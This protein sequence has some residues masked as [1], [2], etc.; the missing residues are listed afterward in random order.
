MVILCHCAIQ[1]VIR[2]IY[3]V[4]NLQHW[5]GVGLHNTKLKYYTALVYL[6]PS[7]L[8]IQVHLVRT[9]ELWAYKGLFLK[10]KVFLK[11]LYGLRNT[12]THGC[13]KAHFGYTSIVLERKKCETFISFFR[14]HLS[15]LISVSP[16]Y[17]QRK[18]FIVNRAYTLSRLL[19]K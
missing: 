15:Y 11:L 4:K 7:N 18:P 14:F 12:I 9:E 17:V 10:T 16:T 19:L 6:Y 13:F 1:G 3:F 5:R 2:I 8:R